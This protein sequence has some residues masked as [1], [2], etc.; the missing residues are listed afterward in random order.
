MAWNPHQGHSHLEANELDG[1]YRQQE[2]REV[3]NLKPPPHALVGA[4]NLADLDQTQASQGHSSRA[5]NTW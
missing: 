4:K 1:D 3:A 2:H 5:N